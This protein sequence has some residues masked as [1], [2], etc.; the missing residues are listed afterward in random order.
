MV[1]L[2]EQVRHA[3]ALT[4]STFQW[5]KGIQAPELICLWVESVPGTTH[6][7]RHPQVLPLPAAVSAQSGHPPGERG[8]LK[9]SEHKDFKHCLRFDFYS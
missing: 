1:K 4:L 5:G 2:I 8:D 3:P 9:A 7:L 6:K